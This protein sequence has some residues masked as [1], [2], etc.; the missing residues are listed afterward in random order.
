[1][2]LGAEAW[3]N[4]QMLTDLKAG[5]LVAYA[6]NEQ[7]ENFF[8]IPISYWG[9]DFAAEALHGL[10]K[11]KQLSSAIPTSIRDAPVCVLNTDAVAWLKNHAVTE[12]D[13]NF[14]S[15]LRNQ[16]SHKNATRRTR[17]EWNSFDTE[18]IKRLMYIGGFDAEWIQ[19]DL[20]REM[21]AW[22]GSNWGKEPSL[23]MVRE[24]V[25][26]AANRFFAEKQTIS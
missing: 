14:P 16:F 19:A 23:R 6:Q 22:C 9:E 3:C 5:A 25:K 7:T 24:R 21:L 2:V 18:A 10:L 11:D 13:I 15:E 12:L 8:R 20:E 26:L 17:Y 1:M 4:D